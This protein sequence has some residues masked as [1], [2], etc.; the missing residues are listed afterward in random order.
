MHL[1]SAIL[2]ISFLTVFSPVS[3][4]RQQ[5]PVTQLYRQTKSVVISGKYGSVLQVNGRPGVA[6]PNSYGDFLFSKKGAG[7]R[8]LVVVGNCATL[9]GYFN[10]KKNAI[11]NTIQELPNIYM[12][13]EPYA[14]K[15]EYQGLYPLQEG[16]SSFSKS[17]LGFVPGSVITDL[18]GA[19][20]DQISTGVDISRHY[21]KKKAKTDL[22]YIKFHYLRE[23]GMVKMGE[24][25]MSFQTIAY[26]LHNV[27][28]KTGACKQRVR[29]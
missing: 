12:K 18:G 24:G 8:P 2:A 16:V 26:L 25:K 15:K 9:I 11:N 28:T 4:S 6:I 3:F 13:I 14:P 22:L 27:L 7:L 20:G 21:R 19:I 23:K 5:V 10:S 17:G 1:W 29:N